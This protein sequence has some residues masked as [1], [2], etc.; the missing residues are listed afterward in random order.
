MTGG[1]YVVSLTSD[2]P[3]AWGNSGGGV[4][5]RAIALQPRRG[6]LPTRP[7]AS[8]P[9]P[10]SPTER[11]DHMLPPLKLPN[12]EAPLWLREK[13]NLSPRPVGASSATS[14]QSQGT[15]AH[16]TLP[17]STESSVVAIPAVTGEPSGKCTVITSTHALNTQPVEVV[18]LR[19]LHRVIHRRYHPVNR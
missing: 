11:P 9:C 12:N 16:S 1:L 3:I 8:P 15:T 5:A 17:A 6:Q 7:P 2:A 14:L 4:I 18:E 19:N 13:L 10:T